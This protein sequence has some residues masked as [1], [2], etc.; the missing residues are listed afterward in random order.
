MEKALNIKLDKRFVAYGMLHGSLN[1]PLVI[2]VHGLPGNC[3]EGFYFSAARWFAKNGYAAYG[4]NLYA[5]QKDARQLKNCTLATHAADL[6]TVVAYF[7]K[8]GVKK[9]FVVGHS[10][11]GPTILLSKNQD[12]DGAVLWDPSH[13][14]SFTKA[15]YGCP[16]GTFV[17]ELG[18]YLTHWGQNVIIGQ[19]MAKEV[20]R[21][22]WNDLPKYFSKPL[23][24]IVA[25]K[26]ALVPAVKRSIKNANDPKALDIIKGATHYFDDDE[27]MQERV[28]ASTK[29]WFDTFR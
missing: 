27:T 10:F 18:G 8:K 2:I 15:N 11:G 23:K 20:D 4:F 3:R 22:K 21:L 26:G 14:I 5:W 17:K 24:M 1:K 12:F 25:G 19:A 7:R 16:A 28:F 9:V 13:D 29:D 6:D